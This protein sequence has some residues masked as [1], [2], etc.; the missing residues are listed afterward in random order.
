MILRL[1]RWLLSTVSFRNIVPLYYHLKGQKCCFSMTRSLQA[2]LSDKYH[3]VSISFFSSWYHVFD[4]TPH[5]AF[6]LWLN[7]SFLMAAVSF[8]NDRESTACRRLFNF[9]FSNTALND[10]PLIIPSSRRYICHVSLLITVFPLIPNNKNCSL[11]SVFFFLLIL[12]SSFIRRCI[13]A[14]STYLRL[15]YG[16]LTQSLPFQVELIWMPHPAVDF[17]HECAAGGG[18]LRRLSQAADGPSAG[19][20]RRLRGL[21][22]SC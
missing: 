9:F 10:I 21:H 7:P 8:K 14:A 19:R 17:S 16:A 13:D 20:C 12:C 11:L 5:S 2:C 15:I 1:H 3:C 6:Q 18:F 4:Y 22:A